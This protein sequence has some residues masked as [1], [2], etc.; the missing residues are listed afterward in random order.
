M[1]AHG[2][3]AFPVGGEDVTVVVDDLQVDARSRFTHRTIAR[4]DTGKAAAQQDRLGLS[5]AIA[6]DVAGRL[7]PGFNDFGI[8]RLPG[9]NTVAQLRK[10]VVAQILQYQHAIDSRWS[11]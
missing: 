3:V 10:T 9:A 7:V 5:V 6:N 2:N 1:D 4:L 8:K 11:A